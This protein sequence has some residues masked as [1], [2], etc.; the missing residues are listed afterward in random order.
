MDLQE[1]SDYDAAIQKHAVSLAIQ[2]AFETHPVP[3]GSLT[4]IRK[5]G[6]T[7]QA[8]KTFKPK[9]LKLAPVCYTVKIAMAATSAFQRVFKDDSKT[10]IYDVVKPG[11][12]TAVVPAF[13]VARAV[14]EDDAN[15]ELTTFKALVSTGSKTRQYQ[16]DVAM[17]QDPSVSG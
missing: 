11:A 15:I 13:F 4:V 16:V 8:T 12:A 5:P 10:Y 2:A 3:G 1:D 14:D 6:N 7:A 9:Q 17:L